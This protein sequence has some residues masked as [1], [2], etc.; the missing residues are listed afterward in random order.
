MLV[1]QV[2]WKTVHCQRK[3]TTR[4]SRRNHWRLTCSPSFWTGT[5]SD[6]ENVL[7]KRDGEAHGE[8]EEGGEEK[9]TLIFIL[10]Y[11]QW[12]NCFHKMFMKTW[13]KTNKGDIFLLCAFIPIIFLPVATL[14]IHFYTLFFFIKIVVIATSKRKP[15]T[16]M[17]SQ[18]SHLNY[19]KYI[20]QIYIRK[21]VN[22]HDVC[23]HEGLNTTHLSASIIS[24]LR[25][26][27]WYWERLS[28][29]N[30]CLKHINE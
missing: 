6:A 12:Q 3:S 4:M 27:G 9:E 19:N 14:T 23:Q 13:L 15:I 8:R 24:I 21:T 2:E 29:L 25:K 30:Y 11:I 26:V 5:P 10:N 16:Q 7:N 17:K 18:V 20:Q 28:V 1:P 22:T